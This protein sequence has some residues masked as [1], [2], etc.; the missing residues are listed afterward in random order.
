MHDSSVICAVSTAPGTGAIAIIRVCGEDAITLCA[1]LCWNKKALQQQA[2]NS[3]ARHTI[4]D[5]TN[6]LD[7]VMIAVFWAP[8]SYTGEN[9]VEI[10]C[11]GSLY[12][13][14]QIMSLLIRRGARPAQAGEFTLRAFLNGKMDLSQAEAVADLVASSSATAQQTALRQMRGGFS[15]KLKELRNQLLDF[16]SL[17]ELELDFS[18]EDIAFADRKKL[19]ALVDALYVKVE[20]MESSFYLGN[21]INNG[22]PVAIVGKPNS[23]KSTLLNTILEDERAI[24]SEI[25]GT[26]RDAIEDTIHL[27]GLLFRFIDTAGLRDTADSIEKF[28]IA[29]TYKKIEKASVILLL[30]DAEDCLAEINMH[31][32]TIRNKITEKQK[33]LLLINKCDKY[34]D[35]QLQTKFGDILFDGIENKELMLLISA[36]HGMG[37][38]R[39]KQTLVHIIHNSLQTHDDVIVTNARHYAALT[40]SK[41]ALQRV[42]AGLKNS[43]ATDL[44]A[45]DIR[46]TLHHIGEITG[47]ITTDE[48]LGNI[49]SK[50]CIGK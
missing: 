36:K 31:I 11:H 7:D 39:L 19:L 43:I 10:Y 21:A 17:I 15:N 41:E 38:D 45:Q 47:E 22:I 24:V 12:I 42:H 26:T 9:S 27:N 30:V 44:I 49:F 16:A 46:E 5:G 32:H 3:I 13:Q 2:A 23:G 25:P 33:L 20:K 35:Q 1:D 14:Q 28:G 6:P 40:K 18:Q 37:I 48:I 8:H 4:C 50:F 34:T 29:I